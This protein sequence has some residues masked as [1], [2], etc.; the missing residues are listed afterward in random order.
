MTDPAPLRA[1]SDSEKLKAFAAWF[2]MWDT[3]RITAARI[4]T[5]TATR[6]RCSGT[7]VASPTPSTPCA[8]RTRG[9]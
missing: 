5:V 8:P 3:D 1:L 4:L 9:W 2:D 6:T 7:S